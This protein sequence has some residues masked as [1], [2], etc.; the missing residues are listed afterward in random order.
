MELSPGARG[1]IN[2]IEAG[3]KAAL[4][5]YEQAVEKSGD[6]MF[7]YLLGKVDSKLLVQA[8]LVTLRGNVILQQLHSA[9]EFT[10]LVSQRDVLMAYCRVKVRNWYVRGVTNHIHYKSELQK[11]PVPAPCGDEAVYAAACAIFGK[12]SERP[13]SSLDSE[14]IL[15]ALR[16]KR[17][18]KSMGNV[19]EA[20][21]VINWMKCNNLLTHAERGQ[22][23]STVQLHAED[24]EPLVTLKAGTRDTLPAVRLKRKWDDHVDRAVKA[25][26]E[27]E[28]VAL[29]A[30]V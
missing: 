29:E 17:K 4:A 13:D 28:G 15:N 18:C 8:A 26:L 10:R 3:T 25:R 21:K 12:A 24:V 23:G 1:V 5:S 2:I 27:R 14:S 30:Q 7:S 19:A 9:F 11:R 16:N 22:R 6:P 20:I